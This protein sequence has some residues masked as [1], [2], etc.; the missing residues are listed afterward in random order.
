MAET[1]NPA[2]S[3]TTPGPEA[4]PAKAPAKRKAAAPRSKSVA[5]DAAA[6]AEKAVAESSAADAA[7]GAA[8]GARDAATARAQ[9]IVDDAAA[10]HG[11]TPADRSDNPLAKLY[12]ELVGMEHTVLHAMVRD[13]AA[14][15]PGDTVKFRPD[16]GEHVQDL[17][18]QGAIAKGTGKEA[19]AALARADLAR[20]ADA[21]RVG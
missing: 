14:L 6:S 12:R 2:D 21:A 19:E 7:V 20:G 16:E 11:E 9:D 17:I 3:T 10:V 15:A 8:Q 5:K 1:L 18:T 4:P 13:N